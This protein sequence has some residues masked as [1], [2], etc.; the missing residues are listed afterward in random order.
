MVTLKDI[1]K[2]VGVSATI[3]SHVLNHRTG[4]T[5][6]SEARR[7][8][9][10]RTAQELGYVPHRSARSL[11]TRHNRT[12][13]ILIN[14]PRY[15]SLTT[16]ER[17]LIFD[18][19]DGASAAGDPMGYRSLHSLV[20]L[21]N[22]VVYE[23]PSFISDR[24]VD[25]LLIYGYIHRNIARKLKGQGF[26]CLHIGT[27][28]D[29]EIDIP[30]VHADMIGAACEVIRRA[31]AAGLS[32]IHLY[33]PRGPGP[34]EIERETLSYAAKHYPALKVTATRSSSLYTDF[35]EAV[36]HGRALAQS[37]AP[38][39]LILCNMNSY[40]P[41]TLGLY[42]RCANQPEHSEFIVFIKEGNQDQRLGQDA[43][44]VSQ[45][46]LPIRDVCAE[47]SRQLISH[48]ESP[49]SKLS[50][51]SLPCSFFAGET[52]PSIFPPGNSRTS[53]CAYHSPVS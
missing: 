18:L 17:S 15:E 42:G 47:A 26:P 41:L 49:D 5:R 20:D 48:L 11:V 45:I 16:A 10:L 4:R 50:P 52:A 44:F 36:E 27:N 2:K 7:E 24:S 35:N 13:G 33:Q 31:A 39:K 43:H 3:V 28:F 46:V 9:I 14:R 30:C 19:L 29:P 37:G 40:Q 1:A 6:V 51:Q 23:Q 25:A 8:E 38:P 32:S 21:R 34:E 53:I 12:I 22:E